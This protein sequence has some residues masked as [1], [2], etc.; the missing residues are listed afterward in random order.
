MISVS[1][2]Y[3]ELFLENLRNLPNDLQ[4]QFTKIKD[5]DKRMIDTTHTLQK[6]QREYLLTHNLKKLDNS[7]QIRETIKQGKKDCDEK[8]R[9]INEIYD[10][11]DNCIRRL[12]S[13][14]S[15]FESELKGGFED[16]KEK[17]SSIKIKTPKALSKKK[18]NKKKNDGKI[19][20]DESSSLISKPTQNIKAAKQ[21]KYPKKIKFSS[22]AH[23]G[24]PASASLVLTLTN[25]PNEVLEMP[26]DPYEPIYCDC[27]DVSYGDMIGCDNIDC[28]IEW[29]HFACVGITD[30]PKGLW[31]CPRCRPKF[32]KTSP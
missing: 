19:T 13:D 7:R 22:D 27:H 11:V 30:K 9:I 16:V 10:S 4:S 28:P 32:S 17:E 23:A 3:L 12:D 29:F 26:T 2:T 18:Y 5:L 14:F 6:H 21:P 31:Y 15:R 8:F 24:I 20:I 25:N 1:N